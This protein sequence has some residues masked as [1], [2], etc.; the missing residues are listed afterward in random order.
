MAYNSLMVLLR[1]FVILALFADPLFARADQPYLAEVFAQGLI[2]DGELDSD[3]SGLIASETITWEGDSEMVSVTLSHPTSGIIRILIKG[4]R[5]FRKGSPGHLSTLLLVSGFATGSESVRLLGDIKNTVLI[6]FQYP[7]GLADFEREPKTI[8]EF[9]R[10]TPAQIALT[11]QWLSEQPWVDSQALTT[12]G[13]SLGGIFLPSSLYLAQKLGAGPSHVVFVCT[14]ADLQQIVG[15]NLK[16]VVEAR[17]G[18]IGRALT[19]ATIPLNPTIY[20]PYLSGTFLSLR[21]DQDQTI[22]AASS[23]KLESLLQG[24]LTV[25]VLRG[26][27]I[28][29]DQDQVIEQVKLSIQ[30]WLGL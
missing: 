25:Q 20:L 1:I 8:F 27:H 3:R 4:P 16:N 17:A 23:I 5:G 30:N 6:G 21:T 12:V 11:L 15:A 26:P 13:V 29:V 18:D 7:F 19:A 22:P 28:N 9:F 24:P 14:G 2:Q 10:R